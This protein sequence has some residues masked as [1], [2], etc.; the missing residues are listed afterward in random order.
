MTLI[1]IDGFSILFRNFFAM[2]NLYNIDG[3][4]IG[5]AVGFTKTIFKIIENFNPKYC[6]VALDSGKPTWRHEMYSLYKSHRQPTPENLIPQF[7]MIFKACEMLGISTFKGQKCEADDWIASIATKYSSDCSNV[8]ICSC[9]K[10][11][12]QLVGNNIFFIDPFKLMIMHE[13][14]VQEKIGVLPKQIPDL[15]GLIGDASDCIPGVPSVGPKTAS[16][17]INSFQTIENILL[18]KDKLTPKSRRDKFIEYYDQAILSRK[19]AELRY[20]L[21]LPNIA[22]LHYGTTAENIQEFIIHYKLEKHIRK[23]PQ[24]LINK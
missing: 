18:N 7:D 2:Q 14:D 15:F 9:D 19:L 12:M 22:E 16:N 5:G 24:I 10:D 21:E 11:L 1:V 13:H 3:L 6:V 17:W 23:Y 4:P 8:Y 20:E